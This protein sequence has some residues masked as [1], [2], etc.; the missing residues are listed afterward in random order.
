MFKD[1]IDAGFKLARRLEK[2][3]G[4]RV[5][6]LA[7]PRGGA[8]VG[9]PVA[10]Y[11]RAEFSL[12]I[13]RKLPYPD[14]P[15]AGFGAVAEDG[16]C[17]LIP[18]AHLWLDR[19]EIERIKEEQVLETLRRVKVLRGGRP[20]PKIEGRT[21]ILVD[22][23]LAVGSTMKAAVLMCRR[24]N[25][26]RVVVAVPVAGKEAVRDLQAL[27][28]EVVVL[29]VPRTFRAVAQ[30][31]EDWSDLSDEEVLQIMREWEDRKKYEESRSDLEG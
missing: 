1:R 25:A 5:Q 13:S 21:V 23:G 8:Q 30:V 12:L 29:E 15:E 10:R 28:D 17:F 11:L 18:N 4:Q 6:V 26:S 31:Y 20:L 7:I 14:E 19:A 27:A 16:S 24:Q 22:D 2:Y 9:Y 3:R